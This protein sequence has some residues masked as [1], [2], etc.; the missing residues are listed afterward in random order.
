MNE[1]NR[2]WVGVLLGLILHGS[3]HFLS[4]KRAAGLKWY[5]GLFACGFLSVAL[6]AVPGTVPLVL[7]AAFGLA[8]VVLWFVMLRQSCRPVRRIGFLGWLAVIVL[9]SEGDG[10]GDIQED[11]NGIEGLR[12]IPTSGSCRSCWCALDEAR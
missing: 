10:T 9:A 3:A 12:R 11:I 4:G 2:K 5:C 1:E 6:V 7:G 8:G